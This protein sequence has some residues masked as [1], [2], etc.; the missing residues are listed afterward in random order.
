MLTAVA[1]V[2]ILPEDQVPRRLAL[3]AADAF[4]ESSPDPTK[5]TGIRWY[6]RIMTEGQRHVFVTDEL[7]ALC[8][9]LETVQRRVA[10]EAAG[11]FI[12]SFADPEMVTGMRWEGTI[13]AAG[14]LY[15]LDAADLEDL[16]TR[17]EKVVVLGRVS[18]ALR[19]LPD[20]AE[21]PPQAE[22]ANARLAERQQL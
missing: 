13:V 18:C 3:E 8:T 2:G 14:Q 4:I 12:D 17:M 19:A 10:L 11:A 1:A 20:T 9:L 21:R 7:A 6:G 5:V 16:C 22:A 15:V